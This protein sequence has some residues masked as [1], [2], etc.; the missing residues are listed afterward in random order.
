MDRGENMEN[1]EKL[2]KIKFICEELLKMET[3][4][5]VKKI[6]ESIVEISNIIDDII[7]ELED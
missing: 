4:K 1:V 2:M 5:K 6:K 3:V 7:K